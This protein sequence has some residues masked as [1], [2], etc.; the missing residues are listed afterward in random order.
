MSR[1]P[2]ETPGLRQVLW[3]KGTFLSP[4]HLQAHDRY[5]ERRLDFQRLALHGFP[6]GWLRLA[7]DEEQLAA[8]VLRLV[9]ARGVLP[10][11]LPI[12]APVQCPLPAARAIEGYFAPGEEH[13]DVYI[14]APE[15]RLFERNIALEPGGRS[16]YLAL[17][18][19]LPDENA[20]AIVR[21]LQ[22]A[23]PNLRLLFEGEHR[24]GHACMAVGR[25]RRNDA[26]QFRLDADFVPPALRLSASAQLR[27][28]ARR[29]VE[30]LQVRAAS[31]AGVRRQ[32]NLNLAEFTAGDIAQFWL[33]HTIH[34]SFPVLRHLV[35][36]ADAHPED[37][38]AEMVELA[39]TLLTFS[40]KHAQ[41][42]LPV[43]RHEDPGACF[44]Q[45]D[46]LIH[47][48]LATVVPAN[49]LS[50]TLRLLQPSIYGAALDEERLF[51]RTQF[52]LGIAA[53]AEPQEIIERAPHL[54]KV[55]S[56]QHIEHLVR[57]ALPGAPL[58]H[59]PRPPVAIPIK[60]RHQYFKIS[61]A[62]LAW[63]AVTRTRT[64]AV[65]VPGDLP[66][67]NVEL[68]AVFEDPNQ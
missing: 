13:L 45:L 46:R 22:V 6:W 62:G 54:V 17:T 63:E 40:V 5:F 9:E 52:Y 8:G 60:L 34:S 33:L 37:L 30:D 39:G 64:L 59:E 11:G 35:E 55:C 14:A 4:Q 50:I 41:A 26:G 25:L 24:E 58:T 18:A 32:K 38:F 23:S 31:L 12:D 28:T 51:Q 1:A 48:L 53:E 2:L 36:T 67:P 20:P 10:D 19:S 42:D 7:V 27:A 57:Q 61:P 49:F 15:E 16:R 56:A 43:Y 47:D 3:L 29:L 68:I 44:G 66:R 21:P 65:Y